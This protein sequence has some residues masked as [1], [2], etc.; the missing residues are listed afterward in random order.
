MR[1]AVG[2]IPPTHPPTPPHDTK[3]HDTTRNDTTHTCS[4]ELSATIELKSAV[5]AIAAVLLACLP[6]PPPPPTD[7][8][9]V[10]FAFLALPLLLLVPLL[11]TRGK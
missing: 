11:V 2:T 7:V 8:F 6:P 10:P 9:K 3:R 1:C 4:S 5:R